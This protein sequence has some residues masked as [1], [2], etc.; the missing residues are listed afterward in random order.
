M[1]HR[2][3]ELGVSSLVNEIENVFFEDRDSIS[4]VLLYETC[5]KMCCGYISVT[6]KLEQPVVE[7]KLF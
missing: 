4:T 3:G 6:Q 7:L 5:P 1:V 2:F